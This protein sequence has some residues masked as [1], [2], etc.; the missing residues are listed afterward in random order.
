MGSDRWVCDLPSGFTLIND[1]D[2]GG[3]G[4]H[5]LLCY[6][7]NPGTSVGI[8]F[9]GG[10]EGAAMAF[11]FEGVTTPNDGSAEATGS[12][13][14]PDPVSLTTWPSAGIFLAV[15]MLDD[16]LVTAT[17]PTDFTLISTFSWGSSGSGGTIMAAYKEVG[18]STSPD[19][20]GGGGDD[21]WW[22]NSTRIL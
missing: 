4:Q 9:T 5:G 12:T 18:A 19:A 1:H 20:F 17:A 22:A 15:G 10:S 6:A 14:M 13:G 7:E 8:T 11:C 21:A 16:D 2:G 3:T